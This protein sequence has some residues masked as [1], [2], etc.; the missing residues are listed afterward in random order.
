MLYKNKLY[1]KEV[2]EELEKFGY[3]VKYALLNAVN[4]EVPQNRERIVV[5]G[6][7]KNKLTYKSE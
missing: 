7:K 3:Y 4:F 2:I 6:S 1:L 5:I